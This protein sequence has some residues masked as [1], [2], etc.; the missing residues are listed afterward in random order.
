MVHDV[1]SQRLKCLEFTETNF[2][3]FLRQISAV[4]IFRLN[5]LPR[6]T[7]LQLGL[8]LVNLDLHGFDPFGQCRQ[9]GSL[10]FVE[11]LEGTPA[12]GAT[13]HS[14]SLHLSIQHKLN[15]LGTGRFVT[16]NRF[17]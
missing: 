13:R 10:E 6:R 9:A 7:A 17:L 16:R 1:Q 3:R 8:D 11:T 5:D 14:R 2:T 12:T 4:V 15:L